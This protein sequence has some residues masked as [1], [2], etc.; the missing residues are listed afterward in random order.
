M[1]TLEE[2]NENVWGDNEF[3]WGR[4]GRIA[5]K[6]PYIQYYESFTYDGVE[7]FL[8]DS[9]YFSSE[10]QQGTHIG[11]IVKMYE[12]PRLKKMVK[13]VWYFRPMEVQRW[14]RGVCYLHNELFLASGEGIGLSNFN[15][16]E[17]ICGKCNV[18][19][20]SEDERNPKTSVEELKMA[21]YVF[22][23]TFDVEKCRLSDKFPYK[24]AGVEVSN[25]FNPKSARNPEVRGETNSF[26]K[27]ERKNFSNIV[28]GLRASSFDTCHL[29]KRKL[30]DLEDYRKMAMEAD[31]KKC[32]VPAVAVEKKCI[33]PTEADEKKCIEPT[34][35]DEKKC[36]E[37]VEADE[38]KCIEPAEAEEK[39]C[40]EPMEADEKKCI[41]P[42]EADEKKC[43]EPDSKSMM[44]KKRPKLDTSEWF[45]KLP[46]E[47]RIQ[48]AHEAG[49][50]I[51]LE[52]LC[53]SFTSSEVEGIVWDAFNIKVS[54]KMIQWRA[55]SSPH[56]GQAL[57]I[58]NS[59][60]E[61]E[62][63]ISELK[64]RCLII[65]GVRLVVGSRP[66]LKE[67]GNSHPSKYF[68]HINIDS[69]NRKHSMDMK[70]AVSTSHHSQPNTIAF[71]MAMEWRA[72]QKKCELCWDAL[73]KLHAE[74]IDNLK[75][76]LKG[77]AFLPKN[78]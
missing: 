41:D 26:T 75:A 14:L 9:V 44:L 21:N 68:G 1:S 4:R 11:K 54:A 45:K 49:S 36:I 46:L 67:P 20:T 24:I 34:E 2:E 15:P 31:E 22:Y 5:T 53:H 18:V 66:S 64:T 73:Y 17:T 48:Q 7:Y 52:N 58:F 35:A 23:R 39:K 78:N 43:I 51:L 47:D 37:P 10:C 13:V 60:D 38:K 72:H 29:K 25:F 70:N 50:L 42:A 3:R 55:F 71:D 6:N 77:S 57:V 40:I 76:S 28:L 74:E 33:E 16:V 62:F 27:C 69:M 61:A 65:G 32:I 19:C 8:Y 12:T 63:A 30:Q 56:N 59:K